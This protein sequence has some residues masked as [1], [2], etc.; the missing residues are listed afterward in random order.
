MQY[1]K[2]SREKEM[3]KIRKPVFG[4]FRIW[5]SCKSWI[6]F[7]YLQI[8]SHLSKPTLGIKIMGKLFKMILDETI[9]CGMGIRREVW[10]NHHQL[11]PNGKDDYHVTLWDV[12]QE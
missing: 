9:V 5:V 3:L 11:H 1:L 4:V 10:M 2:S 7:T 6:F 8:I 12:P